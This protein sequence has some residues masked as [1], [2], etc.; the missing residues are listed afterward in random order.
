MDPVI[1]SFQDYLKSSPMGIFFPGAAN[2]EISPE[3]KNA[4]NSLQSII[5]DK[6]TKSPN[7]ANQEKAKTFSIISG[8]KIVT[9]PEIIKGIIADLS[10][11]GTVDQTIKSVQEMF[12]QN[13]FGIN[14]SGMKDG[15]MN[16]DFIAKLKELENKISEISGVSIS[17]KILSGDKLS[18]DAGDLSKTFSLLKSY[19]D[20]VKDKK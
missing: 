20:F 15:L 14:Y 12:N 3:F 7:P 18:T 10:K 4:A 6:L 19:Q 5:K 13:P 8:D 17:G 9:T 16:A 2:G 1:K 11:E